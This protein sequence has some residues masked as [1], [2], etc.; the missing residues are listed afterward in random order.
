[1]Q[2]RPGAAPAK[3]TALQPTG[4]RNRIGDALGQRRRSGRVRNRRANYGLHR[5][6]GR[7]WLVGRDYHRALSIANC[8]GRESVP[9]AGGRNRSNTSE[10]NRSTLGRAGHSVRGA[11][12]L[13]LCTGVVW[14]LW[15][16]PGN[17]QLG[18]RASAACLW[19]DRGNVLSSCESTA[20]LRFRH[21][22]SSPGEELARWTRIRTIRPRNRVR[23]R[24]L[25]FAFDKWSL[26]CIQLPERLP[27]FSRV[28]RRWIAPVCESRGNPWPAPAEP[29]RTV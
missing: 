17:G 20:A 6:R 3:H 22:V 11:G 27:R 13:L 7:T 16:R 15:H 10:T 9:A 21:D 14:R 18:N 25:E 5:G 4:G 2:R 29:G 8:D 26:F 24:R 19:I 1:M 12:L 23:N 28:D